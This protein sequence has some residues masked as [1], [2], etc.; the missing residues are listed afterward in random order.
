MGLVLDKCC[1][2]DADNLK[3]S[4]YKKNNKQLI[5]KSRPIGSRF[6]A[7]TGDDPLHDGGSVYSQKGRK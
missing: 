5:I 1:G 6:N 4:S 2:A 7:Q 3:Y